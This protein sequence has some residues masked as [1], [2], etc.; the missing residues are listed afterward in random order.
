[1]K[2]GRMYDEQDYKEP[3]IVVG[4]C[5]EEWQRENDHEKKLEEAQSK[6]DTGQGKDSS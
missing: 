5:H 3:I 6:K 1:M 4:L 2:L